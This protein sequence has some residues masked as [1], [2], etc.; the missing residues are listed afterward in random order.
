MQDTCVGSTHTYS[1]TETV[2]KTH[3]EPLSFWQA[4]GEMSSSVIK[5]LPQESSPKREQKNAANERATHQ[6]QTQ[7][8]DVA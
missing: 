7:E 3:N 8:E 4:A 5:R 1:E 2:V 6:E